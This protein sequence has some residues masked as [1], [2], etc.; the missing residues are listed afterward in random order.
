M[1]NKLLN[2]FAASLVVGFGWTSV[3]LADDL[4]IAVVDGNKVFQQFQPAIEEDL[5]KEFKDQQQ[6]LMTMQEELQKTSEKLDKDAEIMSAAEL[7]K[8]QESFA[9][10]QMEFQQLSV[11]YSEVYNE[12]GNEEFQKLIEKV[13]TAAKEL[14]TEKK[15]ALVVQ[16]G[17]VLYSDEKYDVTDALV[18]KIEAAK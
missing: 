8:L 13:Q 11:E 12:R 5:K 16:K 10:K 1:K 15:L 2:I 6:K 9:E 14:A 3:A 7:E 17:A 18:K 4:P